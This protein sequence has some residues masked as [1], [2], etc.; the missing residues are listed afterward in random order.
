M[1]IAFINS[2]QYFSVFNFPRKIE[3]CVYIVVERGELLKGGW[4]LCWVGVKCECLKHQ[5]TLWIGLIWFWEIKH[6]N[7]VCTSTFPT[8][9]NK[10]QFH[11]KYAV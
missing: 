10:P 11:M 9:L 2:I 5:G 8:I 4:F 6:K 7:H 3:L 1:Q